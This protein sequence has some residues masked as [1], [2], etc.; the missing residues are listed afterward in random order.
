MT[1]Y[2]KDL[3]DYLKDSFPPTYPSAVVRQFHSSRRHSFPPT[4]ARGRVP[5]GI[6]PPVTHELGLA[7]LLLITHTLTGLVVEPP[8]LKA[9]QG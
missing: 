2:L 9:G 7:K 5:V 4:L 1:V 3:K 6:L 8:W